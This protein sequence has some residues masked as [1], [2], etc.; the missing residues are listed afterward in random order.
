MPLESRSDSFFNKNQ[1]YLTEPDDR[2]MIHPGAC[3]I[4]HPNPDSYYIF[5][6]ILCKK[7]R[8]FWEGFEIL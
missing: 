6:K 1:E 5:Y 3:R 8:I 4:T 7:N 2:L